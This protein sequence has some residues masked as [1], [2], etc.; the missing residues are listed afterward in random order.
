MAPLLKNLIVVGFLS[1]VMFFATR[2]MLTGVVTAARLQ[3]WAI[4]WLAVASIVFLVPNFWLMLIALAATVIVSRRAEPNSA[5]LFCLIITA[6]PMIG[7]DIPGFFGINR[8]LAP[9]PH[10]LFAV[11]LLL[12]VYMMKRSGTRL[13]YADIAV[14]FYFA[15]TTLLTLRDS[16][17]TNMLRTGT[18]FFFSVLLPYYAM[19]RVPKSVDDF[20]HI[21]LAFVFPLF[22]LAALGMVELLLNWHLYSAVPRFW[23]IDGRMGQKL[24]RDG[25]LRSYGPAFGPIV[26]GYIFMVG[27]SLLL[28]IRATHF[29]GYHRYILL[30]ILGAGL[31]STVSRGPM[32]GLA[33]AFLVYLMFSEAKFRT[34]GRLA[35]IGLF[36]F[37]PLTFTSV[38]Q[39]LISY[40]PF[41]GEVDAG[42][43]TYRVRLFE[44]S[45]TVIA[46]NPLLGSV[47]YLETPEMLELIQGQGIIDLVTS[48]IQVALEYGFVG[49][50]LFVSVF[51]SV[52]RGLRRCIKAL[53]AEEVELKQ[54]GIGL[55]AT[56]CGIL[57]TIATVSSLSF[58]PL[59]Y[60]SLAGLGGG[61][62]RMVEKRLQEIAPAKEE[63]VPAYASG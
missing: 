32:A 6:A 40:L 20:Q 42:N 21:I 4:I 33:V 60:W 24:Y 19:S 45:M 58:I 56:L 49:L 28:S 11:L 8:F 7:R 55:F 38:G 22:G 3:S 36:F 16:S 35:L 5:V 43:T 29:R 17:V 23:G 41:V 48:Y 37:I 30:G 62:I 61:Y 47:N 14:Y 46:R 25:L 57:V 54:L 34:F 18:L 51:L 2:P 44:N 1:T 31:V 12:P 15:L 63:W 10:M 53:P 50:F 52:L 26:F 59:L 13:K 27:A 39:G 9:S